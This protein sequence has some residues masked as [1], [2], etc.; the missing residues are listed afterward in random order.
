MAGSFADLLAKAGLVAS[1]STPEPV[2]P[3]PSAAEPGPA[4]LPNRLAVRYGKKQGSSGK[5]TRVS[6]LVAGHAAVLVRLRAEL[7]VGGRVDGD[8]VVLQ[9]DQVE[10]VARW[11]ES[12]GVAR[13]QR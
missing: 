5:A 11:F 13:V 6:G 7:G 1:P 3:E 12:Q 4:P 2:A 9:G 8:E 10:R